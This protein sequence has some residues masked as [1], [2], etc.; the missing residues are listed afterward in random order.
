MNKPGLSSLKPA[1]AG[2]IV[3][4]RIQSKEVIATIIDLVVKGYI[5]FYPHKKWEGLKVEKLKLLHKPGKSLV[6]ENEFL[7]VLFKKGKE[8]EVVKLKAL[9]DSRALDRVLKKEVKRQQVDLK[10]KDENLEFYIDDPKNV[11]KLD[12]NNRPVKTIEEFQM[13]KRMVLFATISLIG[14]LGIFAL[15]GLMVYF[16]MGR[17]EGE[18][19]GKLL[20]MI[21][22]VNGL[23]VWLMWYSVKKTT[24]I[25]HQ[26]IAYQNENQKR[27]RGKYLQLFDFVKKHAL[28]E[29]R[30][31]NEFL[32]YAIAFG[33][34]THWQKAFSLD[35]EKEDFVYKG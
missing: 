11:V 29:G 22:L 23:G 34:D 12:I 33:F 4:G 20:L 32:P 1:L 17:F 24:K 13:F 25:A 10:I 18:S 16:F 27:L 28:K 21:L 35:A 30:L 2:Y 26:D 19:F 5:D 14:G 8:I 15:V 6:F 7:D 9:L 3:D 31:F